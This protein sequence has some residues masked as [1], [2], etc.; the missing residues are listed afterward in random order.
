MIH[1]SRDDFSTTNGAVYYRTGAYFLTN[2][3]T[4][5]QAT[6]NLTLTAGVRNLF[7]VA[8][9]FTDGFPEPGRSVYLGAKTTF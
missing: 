2:F 8:Y 6:D 5:Y 4:D 3:N 1:G 9:T 7:D